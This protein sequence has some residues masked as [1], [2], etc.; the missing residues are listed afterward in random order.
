VD[1]TAFQ[2]LTR[3]LLASPRGPSLL[4][5]D[6]LDPASAL[7][8][9]RPRL[10][11]KPTAAAPLDVAYL[12]AE[13]MQVE[14]D[15]ILGRGV[16]GLLDPLFRRFAFE[17][18]LLHA[19]QDL[20]PAFLAM[21]R[22]AGLEVQTF[23]TVPA[24]QFPLAPAT[25]RPEALFFPAPLMPLG[26]F[27]TSAEIDTV[28]IWLS[29]DVRR[30]VVFDSVYTFQNHF[31]HAVQRLLGNGQAVLLH[32]MSKAW[33]SPGLCGFAVAPFQLDPEPPDEL[34]L[35]QAAWLLSSERDL[36]SRLQSRFDRLWNRLDVPRPQTGYFTVLPS[37]FSK[38]LAAGKLAIPSSV[39]GAEERAW[40]VGTC[41]LA[42]AGG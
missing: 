7:A 1:Y 22:A 3:D 41:L 33:L 16:R 28:D 39:F 5:L 21:A 15:V 30:I 17:G 38:T 10:P 20:S 31:G 11:D 8:D 26:R 19:P 9:L 35:A 14:G 18:R 27:L 32:S 13:A 29:Q 12:W 23:S 6:G 25:G 36:P 42:E 4:R 34:A 24:P 2:A 37:R 40:C